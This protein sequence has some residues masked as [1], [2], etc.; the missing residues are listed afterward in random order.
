LFNKDVV[1]VFSRWGKVASATTATQLI[2]DYGVDEIYFTGVAGSLQPTL[3]IG[4]VVIGQQVLQYDVDARPLFEQFEIPL[5]GKKYFETARKSRDILFKSV[6]SFLKNYDN[7]IDEK[8]AQEFNIINP[9]V[10]VGT[11]AS[12][13]QF[14]SDNTSV[15]HLLKTL[16]NVCCVEMEGAAVAQVCYEYEVPFSIIRIISDKANDK[17][18]IDFKAFIEKI[19]SHYTLHIFNK[20]FNNAID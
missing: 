5:L 3:E 1:L 12:G 8:L 4:D 17:A 16:P 15:N 19:A 14:I 2:N 10:V 6:D 18:S 11:I 20:F 13:D 9:K 7:F